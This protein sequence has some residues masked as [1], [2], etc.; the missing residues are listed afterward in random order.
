[1]DKTLSTRILGESNEINEPIPI[2]MKWIYVHREH[3]HKGMIVPLD[4]P[5]T[6]RM[7]RSHNQMIG[8]QG[9]EKLLREAGRQTL[10]VI[11]D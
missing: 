2:I 3:F 4:Q 6:L 10:S 11:G 9:F 1:M 8:L 7:I 5:T